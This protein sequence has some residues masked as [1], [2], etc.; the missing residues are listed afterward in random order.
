MT[1]EM[2]HHILNLYPTLKA[3]EELNKDKN[4]FWTK[5]LA[6]HIFNR[7]TATLRKPLDSND[8]LLELDMTRQEAA[9]ER[10]KKQV[11]GGAIFMVLYFLGD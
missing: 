10:E 7:G 11:C 1:P 8:M 6:S 4:V 3:K 9:Q 5:V 2:A